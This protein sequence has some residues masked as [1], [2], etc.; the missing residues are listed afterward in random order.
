[1]RLIEKTQVII[2]KLKKKAYIL[3]VENEK[4]IFY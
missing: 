1:M 4:W 3:Q 2:F